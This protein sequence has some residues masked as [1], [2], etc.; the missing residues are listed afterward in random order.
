MIYIQQ[1]VI[2]FVLQFYAPLT[3]L[4][5]FD[6]NT[7]ISEKEFKPVKSILDLKE[8]KELSKKL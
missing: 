4:R 5:A 3:V 8:L 2:T 1:R 7:K 6:F